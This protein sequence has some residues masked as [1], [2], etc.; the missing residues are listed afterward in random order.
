MGPLPMAD[1]SVVTANWTSPGNFLSIFEKPCF[2]LPKTKR[3]A[4]TPAARHIRP[5]GSLNQPT[6]H[7]THNH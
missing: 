3:A 1:D 5:F 2:D 7:P 6:C 4:V